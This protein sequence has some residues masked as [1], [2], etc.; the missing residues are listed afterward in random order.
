MTPAAT[1]T[2]RR[3]L[4]GLL[5]VVTAAVAWSLRR[6][7]PPPPAT[8]ATGTQSS[9]ASFGEL[10]YRS[11]QEGKENYVVRARASAGQDQEGMH[12]HGVQETFPRVIDAKP[13][14]STVTSAECLYDPIRHKAAC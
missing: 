8:V 5:V 13:A 7:P 10:V 6:P 12:L 11:F 3:A 2:L 1:R 9:G 4:L 14:N